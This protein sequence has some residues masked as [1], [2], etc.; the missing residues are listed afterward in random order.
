MRYR[1]IISVKGRTDDLTHAIKYDA[2]KTQD[3]LRGASPMVT[4]TP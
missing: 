1:E 2:W 4:E 3:H